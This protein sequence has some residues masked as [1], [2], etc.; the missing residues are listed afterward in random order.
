ML[1]KN[2]TERPLTEVPLPKRAVN[3]LLRGGVRTLEE[4]GE[5]TDRNLL[6]LPNFG[7]ASV[8]SLRALLATQTGMH[9]GDH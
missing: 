7:P 6:S 2:R 8:A 5:W 9:P 3:A 4:A 1:E